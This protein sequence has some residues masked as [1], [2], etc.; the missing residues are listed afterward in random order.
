MSKSTVNES[1]GKIAG[2]TV[3]NAMIFQ[4][5][6]ADYQS[7]VEHLRKTLDS[8]DA[9]SAFAGHW[10]F[11]L[12][13]DYHPI[14]YVARE[15]LLALPSNPDSE[16]AV[17]AL[18]RTG[19]EIVRHRAALRHDLMGRIYHRLLAEAKYLGTF[20][21]SIPAATLLLKLA[22]NP[23][24]WSSVDWSDLGKLSALKVGDLA[25]G[26][27]TLLMAAAEAITD[28]YLR[29][30]GEQ[31][32]V[33]KLD[34]LSKLLMEDIIYGYDVVLSALH[35]TASTLALRTPDITFRHM[36]LYP[37]PLGGPHN[38][39]GSIEFL[40]AFQIPMTRDLFGGTATPGQVTAKGDV[41]QP[42]AGLPDLDVCVMN[43]PFTR[44]TGDNLLFGSLP[45]AERH[46]MQ[47]EL[48][49]ILKSPRVYASATAGLGSVFVATGDLHL[50]PG[51]R[52]ALV[53]PKALLS[54]I[55]WQ[56]TRHLL[57]LR[58]QLEYLVVSHDPSRWNFSEN[59]ELSEVLVV[60]RM[61]D[62]P[63]KGRPKGDSVV[64][65]NLWKNPSTA[66]EALGVAHCISKVEPPDL[67]A[68]QGALEIMI[69][70][71]KFGEAVS[72]PWGSIRDGVWILP[73]AFGQS[74]LLRVAY[75]LALGEM[76][77]PWAGSSI[78]IPMCRLGE[79][80]LLGPDRR[81]VMDGFQLAS[82]V[83][84]YPSLWGH[85]AQAVTTMAQLP[86]H[87]L[88]PLHRARSGRPLRKLTDLWPRAG[89]VL[90]AERLR[91]NTQRLAATRLDTKVLSNV[92]KSIILHDG[93]EDDEKALVLWLNSTPSL[94]LFWAHRQETQGAW[95]EFKQW[96]LSE[97]PV[98][99]IHSLTEDKK[100]QITDAYDE[101]SQ[102]TM[103]PFPEMYHDSNREAIDDAIAQ[104][105]DL[106]D[107]TPLRQLL[108]REPGVCLQ[109]LS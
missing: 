15:L 1:I 96:A 81:D 11:V 30:C 70:D 13:I 50:K 58:Y 102:Q 26:T 46:R 100:R 54:G 5:V 33:P 68:G 62:D 89:R 91:L 52:M 6:L 84:G 9:I 104:A 59:T 80:G 25:C 8:E 106:P 93:S 78:K 63:H 27:G 24:R 88:S 72:I 18:A 71:T 77:L 57:S 22:L 14:F 32:T 64:C 105:L 75:H 16:A 48:A 23:D 37:L 61:T 56:K 87:H 67:D 92:W 49:K 53:L 45:D 51:G 101:L 95:V 38:R 83:T 90:I 43:P 107:L 60:A 3:V 94:I 73:C 69:G 31:H 19:L 44:S 28:N 7:G 12:T 10:A 29:A 79:L 17:R 74:E 20:Y 98:L 47:Q 82:G 65:V 86:N 21:T 39:L 34:V 99:D 41:E 66:V 55:A 108:A 97:M 103:L 4:E 36:R 76:L 42:L 35:L 85:D 2:L 109:P 40:R